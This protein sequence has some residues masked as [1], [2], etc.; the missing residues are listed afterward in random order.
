[1]PR[2]KNSGSFKPGIAPNPA[3][4]WKPGQSGNP[5]GASKLRLQFNAGLTEALL[6][7]GSVDKLAD[8][9]WAAANKGEAWAIQYLCNRIAPQEQSLRLIHEKGNDQDV[10]YSK[11]TNDQIRQIRAILE[12]APGNAPRLDDGTGP[13]VL[14]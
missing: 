14:P 13:E 6:A 8:I 12:P 5:A 3:T 10:D 2:R 9:L 1:M 11:L 4:V 7:R